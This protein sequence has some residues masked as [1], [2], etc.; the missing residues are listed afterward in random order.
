MMI[1]NKPKEETT[2]EKLIECKCYKCG[3][4]LYAHPMQD[5]NSP[6]LVDCELHKCKHEPYE[7]QKDTCA[8]PACKKCGVML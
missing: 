4:V 6:Y 1:I 7:Y 5:S 2:I 3:T 8:V